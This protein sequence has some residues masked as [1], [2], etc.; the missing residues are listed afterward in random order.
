MAGN[1]S[2]G[3][4]S[5]R[6]G[7]MRDNV[8]S[9]EAILAD[10]RSMRFGPITE[11]ESLG[12]INSEAAKFIEQL[13]DVGRLNSDS[14]TAGFPNLMR[15]VGGYNV[16]ALL[17]GGVPKHEWR[18]SL[19]VNTNYHPNTA[20]LLVGSEGTLGFSRKIQLHLKPIPKR[21]VLGVCHF[22]SFYK[23]MEV[24]K[25]IVELNPDAVEL[26]DNT[27][28]LLARRT[29]LFKSTVDA[30]V[31]GSPKAILLVEFSGENEKKLERQLKRLG[32]L[33][34]ELSLQGSVV[35]AVNPS[36]QRAIWE[37]RKAGL[38]IMMSMKGD[39]KP[40]SF[41][42]DCAVELE[43]LPEYTAR[44]TE[45]YS[46]NK[47]EGTWYAHASVVCLHVRPILNLKNDEKYINKFFILILNFNF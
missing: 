9:I 20:H 31:R 22:P 29:P 7:T 34:S 33:M 35:N 44:L 10:G 16:D 4:R 37:V 23:A 43:D 26:I 32:A 18:K 40:I 14:I 5:I 15:R 38:N 27:M 42:E 17:P 21:K 25:R 30:F 8:R 36:F 13:L 47:T 11:N 3:A 2:C 45:L 6:Y 46:Q 41:I 12:G 28:I 24:T 19:S 1:N 39:G